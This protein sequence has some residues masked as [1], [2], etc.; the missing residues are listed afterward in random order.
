M[1][2]TT[3]DVAHRRDVGAGRALGAGAAAAVVAAVANVAVSAVARGPL[4]AG[5]GFVPLTPGPVVLWTT[6]GTVVGAVGWRLV[7]TRTARARAV[8]AVLVPAVLVLSLVPDVALLVTGSTPGQTTTGVVALMVM[9]VLTAA[10][11]VT[12]YRR[13]MPAG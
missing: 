4:G 10:I 5:D 13:V 1:T 11:A 8:L 2:S 3:A 6:V 9:H 7:V 12:V